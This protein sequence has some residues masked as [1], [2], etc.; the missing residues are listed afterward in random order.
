MAASTYAPPRIP[1]S[2]YG[3]AVSPIV[4]LSPDGRLLATV[5]TD[6]SIRMWEVSTGAQAWVLAGET[7]PIAAFSSTY[8][9]YFSPDGTGLLV[10]SLQAAPRVLDVAT[11][12]TMIS[13]SGT[14]GFRCDHTAFSADGSRVAFSLTRGDSDLVEVW[15]LRSRRRV[16]SAPYPEIGFGETDVGALSPD[17]RVL[18]VVGGPEQNVVLLRDADTLA[19]LV[20]LKRRARVRQ[21]WFSPDSTRIVTSSDDGAAQVWNAHT[22]EL[23]FTSLDEPSDVEFAFIGSDGSKIVLLYS[24]GRILVHAIAFDDVLEIAKGRV[25]RSLTDAECRTYL[26]VPACPT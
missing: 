9:A 26:H 22:G 2:R 21:L 4:A 6:E 13:P 1:A 19:P 23:I 10:C 24:D 20:T 7:D 15:D 17:G 14:G 25:T 16:A 3:F 11:G 12:E 8:A 5:G 18:A